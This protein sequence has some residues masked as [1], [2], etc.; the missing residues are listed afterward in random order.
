LSIRHASACFIIA[1]ETD[2]ER[3]RQPEAAEERVEHHRAALDVID[4]LIARIEAL[5]PELGERRRS[6]SDGETKE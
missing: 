2:Q 3:W 4:L 5:E 6:A 1:A